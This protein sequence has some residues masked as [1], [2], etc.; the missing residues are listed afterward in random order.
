MYTATTSG[1]KEKNRIKQIRTIRKDAN[2]DMKAAAEF[3]RDPVLAQMR[4]KFSKPFF[5]AYQKGY[6]NYR[7]GEWDVAMEAF[8]ES[9]D[10]LDFTDGPSKA[11][12]DYIS[13]HI[14]FDGDESRPKGERRTVF[15]RK[16]VVGGDPPKTWKGVRELHD[17]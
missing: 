4:E 8:Q 5:Q 15:E 11:L 16:S 13:A 2:L 1:S 10:M 6:L 7:A 17:V 14:C 3:K 12:I 9:L